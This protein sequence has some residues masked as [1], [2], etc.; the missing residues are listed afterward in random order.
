MIYLYCS[1][2]MKDDF[3]LV[4]DELCFFCILKI[5]SLDCTDAFNYTQIDE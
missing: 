4:Y 5:L 3:V 1:V 2:I